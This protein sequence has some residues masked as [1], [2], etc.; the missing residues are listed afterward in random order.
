MRLIPILVVVSALAAGSA[1]ATGADKGAPASAAPPAETAFQAHP[2]CYAAGMVASTIA[3]A[4][5]SDGTDS[6]SVAADGY[7]GTIGVGCDFRIS[8][9]LAVGVLGRLDLADVKA[10]VDDGRLSLGWSWTAAA[11]AGYYVN[12][13]VMVYAL[14]GVTSQEFKA[15]GLSTDRFGL[16]YGLGTEIALTPSTALILEW[17]RT[18]LDAW[19]IDD[20]RITPET[21]TVRLGIAIKLN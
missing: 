7:G 8:P 11:R 12:P 9:R 10:R 3:K 5:A 15:A 14:A 18:D 4:K 21:D 16:V 19:R 2:S 20:V 13:A 17:T 6:I 1:P